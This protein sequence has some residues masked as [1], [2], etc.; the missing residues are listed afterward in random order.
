MDCR[1]TRVQPARTQDSTK[2]DTVSG[3]ALR[4]EVRGFL[5]CAP[6]LSY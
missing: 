5:V 1:L 4:M 3:A 2:G 6:A